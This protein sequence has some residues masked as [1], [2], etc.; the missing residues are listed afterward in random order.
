MTNKKKIGFNS[1]F[2]K[3]LLK[4]G[5]V[6]GAKNIF[7]NTFN[8]LSSQTGL[9]TYSVLTD[10]YLRLYVSFEIRKI[11]KFRSSHF[12]PIPLTSKRRNY[13]ICKWI[14]DSVRLDKTQNTFSFKLA[15][16]ILKIIQNRP[17]E[18]MK[19]KQM[20]KTIAMENRANAHYRW[21]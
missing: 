10:V 21:Y 18:S 6:S 11:K 5:N 2:L 14:F 8:I 3:F 15:T 9:G 12:V 16:E 4:K 1:I 13:L 19:K 17:C 7:K 20:A